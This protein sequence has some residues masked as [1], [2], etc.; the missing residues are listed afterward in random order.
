MLV[1]TLIGGFVVPAFATAGTTITVDSLADTTGSPDCTL[2][3]AITSADTDAATGGCPAGVSTGP[4][5]IVFSVSG[6]IFL[7]AALPTI[8]SDMS[9]DGSAQSI[10]IDGQKSVRAFQVLGGTVSF[11]NIFVTNVDATN[12]EGAGFLITA[13][14]V[15]LSDVIVANAHAQNDAGV[16]NAGGTVTI[17][18]SSF[19]NNTSNNNAAAVGNYATMTIRS[20]TFTGNIAYYA[21][22]AVEDGGTM[23][24]ANSTFYENTGQQE[25][26]ALV[27]VGGQFTILNSTVVGNAAL[28]GSA[29]ANVSSLGQVTIRNSIFAGSSPLCSNTGAAFVVTTSFAQDASCP[30]FTKTTAAHLALGSLG[31]YGGSTETIPLLPWS[32]AIN[33]ADNTVCSG[34]DVGSLDQRGVTRPMGPSCDLGAFELV[35]RP[36]LSIKLATDTSFVGS[37]I[38]SPTAAG[39]A[40]TITIPAGSTATFTLRFLNHGY[41][42]DRI[43]ISGC[44]STASLTT[45]FLSG[46]TNVT[47]AVTAG[48]FKTN[49]LTPNSAQTLTL[50]ATLGAGVSSGQSFTCKVTGFSTHQSGAKDAVSAVITAS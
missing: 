11:S 25:G 45:S 24:I 8:D 19:E 39:E 35:Y 48:T 36:D 23:T 37:N 17:D 9:I 27:N 41:A 22:G 4:D 2:R 20:S 31:S 5:A 42:A 46:T 3:D 44:G 29:L 34:A 32:T 50:K 15:A 12:S 7:G 14:T 26:G 40:R 13:G 21:G 38:Y 6:T 16:R 47:P 33:A 10:T 30:G 18:D 28:Y 1:G 43:R 49:S